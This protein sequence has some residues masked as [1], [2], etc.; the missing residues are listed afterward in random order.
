MNRSTLR[1]IVLVLGL[2]TAI[3]HLVVLNVLSGKVDVLFTLNGLGYL[4]L[5]FAFYNPSILPDRRDL[6]HYALMAFAL[7]TIIAWFAAGDLG[8]PLGIV[9]K[10]V[11]AL[12]II[13]T[14]MHLR[15]VE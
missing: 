8:D 4:A 14:W 12:L 2:F 5:L 7:V 1:V 10:I 11:E 3:V 6:V 15:A 13:A 9:T